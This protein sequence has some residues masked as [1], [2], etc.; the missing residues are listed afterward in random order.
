MARPNS[1][2]ETIIAFLLP[3]FSAASKDK[4]EARS[5]IIDTL[6]CYETRT[7]AEMLQAAHHRLRHDHPRRSR[8]SQNRRDVT[9]HAP[10]TGAAPTAS[11]APPCR[12][13]KRSTSVSATKFQPPPP[14]CR[15]PST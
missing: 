4:H 9:I 15:S 10:P 1:F 6:A 3:Y 8:R 14:K 7:R 12:P 5:E 11:I 13:K 2:L